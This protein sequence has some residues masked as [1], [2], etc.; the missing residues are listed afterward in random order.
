MSDNQTTTAA[1]G[2]APAAFSAD[3]AVA[4]LLA[5]ITQRLRMPH[6]KTQLPQSRNNSSARLKRHREIASL[7]E[8][9]AELHREEAKESE[10]TAFAA[11]FMD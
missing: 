1:P 2:H 10:E 3:A 5:A 9:L 7:Y 4:D 8:R 6:T 11:G